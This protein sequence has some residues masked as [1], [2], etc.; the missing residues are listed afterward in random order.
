M[1]QHPGLAVRLAR[2]LIGLSIAASLLSGC[3]GLPKGLDVVSGFEARRYEGEWFEIMRLDHRFERG[4]SNITARYSI[5]PDGRVRVLNK[6]FDTRRCQWR[7]VEGTARFLSDPAT[8]SLAV[9]FF[10]PFAGGY[11]VIE[12]DRA[13]YQWA[14]VSGPTRG[15]LWIL[16]RNPALE[17]ATLERLVSRV[18]ELGFAA[19]E[20]IRVEHGEPRCRASDASARAS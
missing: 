11:H 3:T 9:S 16:A 4:L 13:D 20:L 1:K 5:L 18:R 12:L 7:S 17:P 15:Y 2:S 10:G 8:A 14:V 19:D 6:G